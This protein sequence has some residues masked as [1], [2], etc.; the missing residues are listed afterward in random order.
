VYGLASFYEN[1][2][3]A[4]HPRSLQRWLILFS[5]GRDTRVLIYNQ[6]FKDM[7]KSSPGRSIGVRILLLA[8]V[9]R[10]GMLASSGA[11]PLPPD[12][13]YRKLIL[14]RVEAHSRGDGAGYLKLLT[15]DFVHVDDTGKR[16]TLNE[17]QTV[18]VAN[19]SHWEVDKL[20]ARPLGESMAIVDCEVTEIV[21]FGPREVRMPLHETDVFVLQGDRWLFKE[22]AETHA[23]DSPKVITPDARLLDDYVGSYEPWPGYIETITRKGDQLYGQATGDSEAGPLRAASDES[24]FVEGEPG[25]IV[26]VRGVDGKVTHELIHF[27]DGKII[28]ARKLTSTK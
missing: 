8:F 25:L 28:V 7:N 13:M 17:M 11:D 10:G 26:F 16:R 4:S 1:T 9:L 27:P 12:E 23:L 6:Q 20:H 18:V 5:L 19:R 14:E 15:D 3:I 22:H 21:P 24:F 2:S